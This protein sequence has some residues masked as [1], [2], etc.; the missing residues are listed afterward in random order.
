MAEHTTSSPLSSTGIVH[1]IA[2]LEEPGQVV[3]V[4]VLAENS[5]HSGYFTDGDALDCSPT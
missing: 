1:A 5:T 4:R 3:E 2:V